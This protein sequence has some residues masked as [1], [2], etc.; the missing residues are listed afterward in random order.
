M[1]EAGSLGP[2][3]WAVSD[4]RAGNAAQV[5]AVL[6]A[7]GDTRRWIQIAH[8]AGEAHRADPLVLT[9][10]IPWRWL[11]ADKWPNPVVALPKDQRDLLGPPWPTVWVAAGRRSAALTRAV[12]ELSGGKTL[13]VQILDPKI[14]PDNFDLLVTPAHDEVSGPNVIQTIGSP[15]YFPPDLIEQAGQ[16][17]A[18]LADERGKSAIVIL[19]GNS[20]AHTFTDAAAE[21]LDSQLRTLAGQGWR[22]RITTSRRTPVQIVA[23]FR[24]MAD[25][26]GARFWAGPEDGENPYLAWLVFSDCAIVTEDSANMLSDAAWHNLPIHIARLEGRSEK[27]DKLHQS[28]IDHGAAR[29]FGGVLETW[30]YPA[31]READRVADAIVAKLLERHPQPSMGGDDTK[32]AP[33]DWM[34]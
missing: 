4:G 9:P 3:V 33:P 26:I 11:P 14:S 21:R 1:A 2:S 28:L 15:S 12:R 16:S 25:E 31:L 19:G 8:I 30:T 13:T 7:L 18:D 24:A 10:R 27:F 17:F 34:E 23:R 32:V 6:Q 20:K 22:L 5:R 29:L